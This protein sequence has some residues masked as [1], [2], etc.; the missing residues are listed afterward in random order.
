MSSV[1]RIKFCSAPSGIA[2]LLLGLLVFWRW[3]LFRET[4]QLLSPRIVESA[5][6][7]SFQVVVWF[8]S[9]LNKPVPSPALKN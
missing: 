4:E 8:E 9:A 5:W 7:F 3:F 6:I 2:E 1:L